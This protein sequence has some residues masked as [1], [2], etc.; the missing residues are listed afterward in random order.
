MLHGDS[1]CRVLLKCFCVTANIMYPL[2]KLDISSLSNNSQFPRGMDM[3]I[4]N[5]NDISLSI[6]L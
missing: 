2:T 3:Y 6:Q 4:D 1:N 5:I